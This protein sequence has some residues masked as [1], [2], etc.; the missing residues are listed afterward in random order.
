MQNLWLNQAEKKRMKLRLEITF[1]KWCSLAK[2][3]S[4]F[5]SQSPNALQNFFQISLGCDFECILLLEE[6]K[7]VIASPVSVMYLS[8]TQQFPYL[9]Y[10]QTQ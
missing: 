4:V 5:L 6:V 2:Q 8:I 1:K 9:L 3:A 10:F 7:P